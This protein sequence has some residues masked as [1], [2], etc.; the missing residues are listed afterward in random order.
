[1]LGWEEEEEEVEDVD[2]EVHEDDEGLESRG[3]LWWR[4]GLVVS[5]SG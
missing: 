5:D 1:M 4:S 3:K 2:D